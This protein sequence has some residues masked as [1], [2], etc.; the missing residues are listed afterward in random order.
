VL[1]SRTRAT[2]HLHA[3]GVA[4]CNRAASANLPGSLEDAPGQARHQAGLGRFEDRVERVAPQAIRLHMAAGLLARF[5][6]RIEIILPV[7]L[8]RTDVFP[9]VTPAHDAVN[10]TED[11]PVAV[12][13]RDFII[14]TS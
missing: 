5:G 2:I 1:P 8:L 11:I 9:A 3:R 4:A 7:C 6:W 13:L 14:H 10:G 12:P